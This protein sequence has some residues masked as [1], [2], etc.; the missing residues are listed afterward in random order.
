[1][2]QKQQQQNSE[3]SGPER[4]FRTGLY[5]LKTKRFK[6]AK[7]FFKQ[8]LQF[9][10][11]EPL[12]MSY[13]GLCIA[14]QDRAATEAAILCECAIEKEFYRP[15][16]YCNLGKVYMLLGNR[17]KAHNAFKKGLA[18]DSDDHEIK[19][20]LEKMGVRKQPMFPFLKRT[21]LLNRYSG[22]LLSILQLR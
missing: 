13:L 8:A 6:E 16:L 9:Q 20:E 21:H 15:E 2:Q 17:R 5:N 22:R 10:P 4:L 3:S 11:D 7:S 18:L 12:Y 14:M 1:M 19:R